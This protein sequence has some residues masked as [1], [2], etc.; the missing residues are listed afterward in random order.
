MIIKIF[1]VHPVHDIEE[2]LEAQEREINTDSEKVLFMALW[3][4]EM[5]WFWIVPMLLH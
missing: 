5:G 3:I 2:A 4:L 1:S